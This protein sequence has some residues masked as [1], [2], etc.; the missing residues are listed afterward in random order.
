MVS[1]RRSPT[2]IWRWIASP[3]RAVG[4]RARSL[5]RGTAHAVFGATERATDDLMAAIERGSRSAPVDVVYVAH[6]Q[7]ALLAAK[8]GEWREAAR[9]ARE[10]QARVDKWGLGD[11]STS[12]LVHV[13][14]ARVALHETRARGCP[15]GAHARPSPA[16]AARPRRSL[17]DAS[18]SAS[19]SHAPISRSP[20]PEPPER[21]SPRPSGYSSCVRTWARWSTMHASCAPAWKRAPGPAGAWAMSLTGGRAAA[22]AVPGHPSHVPR[23]REPAVHLAQH[24]QDRGGRDLPQARGRIAQ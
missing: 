14:T 4:D 24:G 3:L 7:L 19:S 11:Y 22:A 13:A 1:S 20:T 5:V 2:P 23:D 17:A 18:R 16:A 6:A 8:R 21:S 12:A 15:R 9:L 10:A